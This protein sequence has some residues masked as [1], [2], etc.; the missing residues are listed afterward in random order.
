MATIGIFGGIGPQASNKLYE[1]II[2]MT[3]NYTEAALDE[4]YPDIVLLN[5]PVPNFISD[6]NNI[7]K[8]KQMLLEKTQLLEQ[9]GCKINGIAC[10]TVH[11]LLPELQKRTN[12]PFLSLPRLAAEEIEERGY[13]RVGLL[14]TPTTLDSSLYDDEIKTAQIVR[15][16]IELRKL[17]EEC[18][19]AELSGQLTVQQQNELKAQV[20]QFRQDEKLDAVILG[21]TELPLVYGDDADQAVINTLELLADGLLERYFATKEKD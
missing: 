18:I 1:L 7:P 12:V 15:P 6:K 8:A 10:N 20:E 4:D 21:C 14:A 16:P 9:A 13:K 11:L 19:Y 3:A 2:N 17:V 5:I